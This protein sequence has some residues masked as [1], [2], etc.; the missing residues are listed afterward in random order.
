MHG[1][2]VRGGAYNRSECLAVC[3]G[4]DGIMEIVR[5]SDREEEL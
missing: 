3:M 2:Y 4:I 5:G 1:A